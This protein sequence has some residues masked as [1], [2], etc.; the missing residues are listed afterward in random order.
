MDVLQ[1]H[2]RKAKVRG[3]HLEAFI[4]GLCLWGAST[5]IGFAQTDLQRET[6]RG[7]A[8]VWVVVEKLNPELDQAGLTRTQLQ[9]DAEDRLHK[10]GIK[11]LTQDECW[12]T[13]GMPWLYITVALLK[14]SETTY[15]ATIG[16]SLNQEITL[17][18]NPQIKTFGV[19]WDAG[20]HIGTV[21]AD[22]LPTVR[23]SV[24]GLIDKF[25]TDYLAV[26]QKGAE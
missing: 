6:L 9:T 17:T 20:V 21:G 1:P 8:G 22:S 19:T 24:G 12:T 14:A 13:P 16:T 5:S 23:E 26:N 3:R 7:L 10:V 25:I 11:V 15:A 4:V 2:R 18:R